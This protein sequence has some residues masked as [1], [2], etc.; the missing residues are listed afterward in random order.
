[1]RS[2]QT[3]GLAESECW[4]LLGSVSLGRV[5]FTQHALPAIR[6]VNH[7]V[8]DQVVIIRSHLGAAMVGRAARGE[9]TVVCYQADDIDA[10]RHTGWSVVATG[11]A[12]LLRDPAVIAQYQQL[13]E[14]WAAG[15][16]DYVIAVEPQVITGLRLV[17]W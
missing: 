11:I 8:D 16:M 12:R 9:G 3:V 4:R 14:P 15:R 7:L 5:V 17:G 13:L 1:M 10:V 6:P 2:R